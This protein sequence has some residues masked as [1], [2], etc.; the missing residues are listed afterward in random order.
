MLV[1]RMRSL[2]LDHLLGAPAVS[3]HIGL[4][5]APRFKRPSNPVSTDDE[6]DYPEEALL[7]EEGQPEQKFSPCDDMQRSMLDEVFGTPYNLQPFTGMVQWSDMSG[8]RSAFTRV[9][10]SRGLSDYDPFLGSQEEQQ[11]WCAGHT[12]TL[13]TL[14]TRMGCSSPRR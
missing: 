6:E 7:G 1:Q 3:V 5:K 8:G 14:M 2:G 4:R 13:C 11:R 9:A 12:S 10:G